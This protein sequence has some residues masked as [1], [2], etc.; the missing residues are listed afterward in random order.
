[1]TY[2]TI[3]CVLFGTTEQDRKTCGPS[4]ASLVPR[5]DRQALSCCQTWLTQSTERSMMPSDDQTPVPLWRKYLKLTM[6]YNIYNDVLCIFGNSGINAAGKICSLTLWSSFLRRCLPSRLCRGSWSQRSVTQRKCCWRRS[7]D[8]CR[9]G[10][11]SVAIKKLPSE[12]WWGP[13]QREDH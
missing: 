2:L 12:K 1:M 10:F 6:V 3:A 4:K 9:R 5:R 11:E 8:P 13:E 7:S